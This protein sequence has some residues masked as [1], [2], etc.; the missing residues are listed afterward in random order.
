M[1][2]WQFVLLFFN[3]TNQDSILFNEIQHTLHNQYIKCQ[4]VYAGPSF[5]VKLYIA[6]SLHCRDVL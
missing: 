4:T 3:G 5:S 1:K 2:S 6:Y